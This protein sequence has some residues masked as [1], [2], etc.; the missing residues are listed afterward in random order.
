MRLG[1]TE[2]INALLL[3]PVTTCCT[4]GAVFEPP[5]VQQARESPE[6]P[7]STCEV[8]TNQML[9]GT[10]EQEGPPAGTL[11]APRGSEICQK[12]AKSAGE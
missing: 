12:P 9:V 2:S 5:S 8:V 1:L 3:L 11:T 10:G 6:I 7:L 4:G